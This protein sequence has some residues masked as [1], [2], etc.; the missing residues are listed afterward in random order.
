MRV[1]MAGWRRVVVPGGV[2]MAVV[3]VM[4]MVMPVVMAM[5][6]PVVVVLVLGAT[7]AGRAHQRISTSARRSS[8]PAIRAR[9][10]L[11]QAHA[12]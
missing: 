5:V 9:S 8:P 4:A 6:M 11:P 10:K 1:R 2:L 7:A 3:V 12:A